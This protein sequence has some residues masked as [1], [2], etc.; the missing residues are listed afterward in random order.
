VRQN[1]VAVALNLQVSLC[2]CAGV[3]TIDDIEGFAERFRV[4]TEAVT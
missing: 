1:L 4:A 2:V 3:A